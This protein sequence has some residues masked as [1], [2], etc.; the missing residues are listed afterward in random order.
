M[1]KRRSNKSSEKYFDKQKGLS[2]KYIYSL[3]TSG[4]LSIFIT[5]HLH[6]TVTQYTSN[7]ASNIFSFFIG[8][9]K[10]YL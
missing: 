4:A 1:K 5:Y 7:R 6:R 2:A 9:N 10:H 8:E 3:I